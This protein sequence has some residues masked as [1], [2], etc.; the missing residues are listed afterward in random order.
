MRRYLISGPIIDG[1]LLIFLRANLFFIFFCGRLWLVLDGLNPP[2]TLQSPSMELGIIID[3]ENTL[4][5]RLY[6]IKI[7]KTSAYLPHKTALN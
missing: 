5:I 6:L 2:S 1:D 3:R 7:K 4:D